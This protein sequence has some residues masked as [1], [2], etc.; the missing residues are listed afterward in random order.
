MIRRT[1]AL[2]DHWF[3]R[4][5]RRCRHN[6]INFGLPRLPHTID[7]SADRYLPHLRSTYYFIV[8][9]FICEPFFKAYCTRYGRNVHTGV[10]LHW[11]QGRGEIDYRRQCS[12]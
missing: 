5:L 7:H 6:L 4:L 1:L 3:P 12:D 11:I 10:F 9:V 2:S 8:R